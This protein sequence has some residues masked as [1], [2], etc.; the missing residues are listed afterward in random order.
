MTET[1]FAV[2]NLVGG[3]DAPDLFYGTLKSA[4]RSASFEAIDLLDVKVVATQAYFTRRN[5]TLLLCMIKYGSMHCV[6]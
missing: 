1:A 6:T 2:V 5:P 3:E 4:G